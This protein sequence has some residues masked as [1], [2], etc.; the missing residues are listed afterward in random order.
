MLKICLIR[1]CRIIL[2]L[3]VVFL[4]A[5]F[6]FFYASPDVH[7]LKSVVES[8]VQQEFSADPSLES[9]SIS[10]FNVAW[11][12]G[13]VIDVGH[14]DIAST[15]FSCRDTEVSLTYPLSHLLH[16]HFSPVFK[17]HGGVIHVNLDAT[18]T[19]DAKQKNMQLPYATLSLEDVDIEWV[20]N[21][22]TQIC[23]NDNANILP[24]I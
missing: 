11:H 6:S 24:Q 20:K 2:M 1:G 3:A 14:V 12:G 5:L 22:K 23:S 4:F 8:K 9:I 7:F 19:A 15:Y 16:G 10:T 13:P 21:H 18:P 17:L